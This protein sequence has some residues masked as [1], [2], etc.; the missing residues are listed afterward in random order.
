VV[1]AEIPRQVCHLR[2]AWKCVASGWLP[3]HTGVPGNEVADAAVE[4]APLYS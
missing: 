3:F 2:D 4:E 1:V